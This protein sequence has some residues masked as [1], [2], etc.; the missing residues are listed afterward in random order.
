MER[1]RGDRIAFLGVTLLVLLGSVAGPAA[2]TPTPVNGCTTIDTPGTY[3]LTTD[4]AD[5]SANPCIEITAS[6][7]AFDG[8]NH[9]IDG[10]GSGTGIEVSGNGTLSNVTV[11][12]TTVTE[13]GTAIRYFEVTDG[14]VT[15]TVVDTTSSVGIEYRSVDASVITA[16]TVTDSSRDGIR[17]LSSA[18]N[19]ISTTTSADHSNAGVSLGSGSSNTV[20]SDVTVENTRVGVAVATLSN[21]TVVRRTTIAN[22]SD[23][24]VAIEQS[25][26]THLANTTILASGGWDLHQVDAGV[27]TSET[28]E[29]ASG[30]VATRSERVAFGATG[31]LPPPPA[32]RTSP[33]GSPSVRATETSTGGSLFLNV[34]YDAP[35]AADEST[36]EMWR[37]DGSWSTVAGTNGVD[38]AAD[39]VYAN[40]TTF[41]ATPEE[42]APFGA[43]SSSPTPTP[44]PTPTVTPTA[45][46]TNATTAT[47]LTPVPTPTPTA[48]AS[49][50]PVTPITATPTPTPTPT[51][52]DDCRT[53]DD[54]GYYVL[55]TDLLDRPETVC[56]DIRVGGV[57]FDG[58]GHR[59]DSD[60]SAS[61]AA[62]RAADPAGGTLANV[63]VESVEVTDWHNGIRYESVDGGAVTDVTSTNSTFGVR[64]ADSASIAVDGVDGTQSGEPTS[65][66]SFTGAT[67]LLESTT[68]S[69]VSDVSSEPIQS[70]TAGLRLHNVNTVTV[71][72]VDFD[73]DSALGID[74]QH[75]TDVTLDDVHVAGLTTSWDSGVSI[76]GTNHVTLRNATVE[77]DGWQGIAVADA[78][79]TRIE[80]VSTENWIGTS[81]MA[82]HNAANVTVRRLRVGDPADP[83]R[84]D[85][86]G[87]NFA[88]PGV[89]VP[90]NDPPNERNVSRYVTV[91]VGSPGYTPP[92]GEVLVNVSYAFGDLVAANVSE[93]TLDPWV[94]NGSWTQAT[95]IAGTNTSAGHVYTN[96]SGSKSVVVAPMGEPD[97]GP[98][99]A[100]NGGGL[101]AVAA[102]AVLVLLSAAYRRRLGA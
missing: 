45:N 63:D 41:A 74:V 53:I 51:D 46:G 22:S 92:S 4:V 99:T 68:D 14:T 82:E 55:T 72:S 3:Q 66:W 59:I 70:A 62:I 101:G 81:L 69:T 24:G 83:T 73:A 19:E 37:H 79:D 80:N 7:V 12:N 65:G 58:N 8:A 75:S 77:G 97:S 35:G 56:I 44:T 54:P 71:E 27:T 50:P 95:G 57:R 1:V 64:V 49:Q 39:Y 76:E 16:T 25:N 13:W 15:E 84:V 94:H 33:S 100:S 17:L 88:I 10:V 30:T 23:H 40:V 36:L 96:V 98:P 93:T 34:S 2:A 31:T 61:N 29:L 48:T 20:L 21:D 78:N 102:A 5:S 9:T 60:D 67:I 42:F 11:R 32:G 26:G 85:A 18:Q 47:P 52:V 86:T 43:N 87:E 38:T 6:D 91:R 89:S 90:A 28:L